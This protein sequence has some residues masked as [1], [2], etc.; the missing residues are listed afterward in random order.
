MEISKDDSDFPSHTH[1]W[2]F[3]QTLLGWV[4]VF[5]YLFIYF[6]YLCNLLTE[7]KISFTPYLERDCF[8]P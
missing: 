4:L 8:N 3:N 7:Q 6:Y 1:T 5:I 2:K